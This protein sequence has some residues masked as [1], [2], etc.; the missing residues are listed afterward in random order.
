MYNQQF[1]SKIANF[2][3]PVYLSLPLSGFLSELGNTGRP[4]ETSVMGLPSQERILMIY[5][6]AEALSVWMTSCGC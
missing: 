2:P 5:L 4:G 3:T 1:Q 6:A